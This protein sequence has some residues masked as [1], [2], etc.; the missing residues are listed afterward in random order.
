MSAQ[1]PDRSANTNGAEP[2]ITSALLLWCSQSG[3]AT[4]ASLG[5]LGAMER[6]RASL[7]SAASMMG[8]IAGTTSAIQGSLRSQSDALKVRQA[9][10]PRLVEHPRCPFHA[11]G[12][13]PDRNAPALAGCFT[14]KPF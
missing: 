9:R 2:A 14:A 8:D 12:L 6:E 3:A 13:H 4:G 5:A 1:P 7:M 11:Y 10:A